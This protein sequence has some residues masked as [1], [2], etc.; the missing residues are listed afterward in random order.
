MSN[1]P[2]NDRTAHHDPLPPAVDDTVADAA[3]TDFVDPDL[4][5][6]SPAAPPEND[7]DNDDTDDEPPPVAEQRA[8]LA[9]TVDALSARLDVRERARTQAH[10]SADQLKQQAGGHP[11]AMVGAAGALAAVVVTLLVRRRRRRRPPADARK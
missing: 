5:T 11:A 10:A 8:E 7:D 9:D 4:A 6:R 1:E 3:T 2:N